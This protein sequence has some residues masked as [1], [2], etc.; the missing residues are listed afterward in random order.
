MQTKYYVD[1][2]GRY[3]G[4]FASTEVN[5]DVLQ[6]EPPP[7][8][9]EVSCPPEHASQPWLGDKWGEMPLV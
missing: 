3:L 6:A 2:A 9:I 8:S 1:V 4:A 5:G 7:G